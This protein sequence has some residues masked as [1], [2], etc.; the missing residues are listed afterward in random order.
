MTAAIYARYSDPKQNE[1]SIT[2]QNRVAEAWAKQE[3]VRVSHFYNDKAM[4]GAVR[5]RPDYLKM[6]DDAAA[7]LFEILIIHDLS[8]LSR[9]DYEL[10]GVLRKLIWLGVRVIGV[11][12]GY[13]STRSGHKIH[14]GFK[15]LMN[16]LHL[17]DIRSWTI[18]GMKGKAVDGFN[19]GGRT[20]GYRNVPIEDPTG[21]KDDYGRPAIIAV[22]YEIDEEQA[23]IV[24]KIYSWYAAGY[25]YTWIASELNKQGIKASRG[26][27]WAMTAI[28]VILDNEMY[29]GT[30]IWNRH[31]WVKH[32]DSGKRT[33]K[34]RP[35]EEW[36]IKDMPDLRIVPE[37]IMAAV[38]LRQKKNAT[39]YNSVMPQSSRRKYLFSGLMVCA[40]CGGNFV[41]AA[42]GRYGCI[43]NKNR[44]STVC[45]NSATVSRHIIEDRLL[46]GIKEQLLAPQAVEKFKRVAVQLL[47]RENRNDHK[48]AYMRQLK[49]AE[50][51]RDNIMTAIKAGI[52]TATTKTAL[53]S[54][55]NIIEEVK[56]RIK[57]S[58]RLNLSG[59]LPR[60]TERYQQAIQGLAGEFAGHTDQAREIIRSL[61][62]DNIMIH[63]RSG[64][65][66]AEIKS[67]MEVVFARLIGQ[68]FDWRGCG[69]GI[70]SE[71]NFIS[72]EPRLHDSTPLKYRETNK[73]KLIK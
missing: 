68:E 26:G 72:L 71:S 14:S 44:G 32:P 53:E 33:Y 67:N 1:V 12:D 62:G 34:K 15:G 39:A 5:A 49:E 36:V 46:S 40:E 69:G 29:T 11:A 66:E 31:Q 55:E 38:R 60:A 18:K 19:C 63:R 7:G 8:R 59:I 58:E 61:M 13:D 51:E 16:E 73:L 50:R 57:Q 43:M 23:N 10:K 52:V 35:R 47:E 22:K 2:D 45:T 56:A 42:A 25:S 54:C 27:S 20:Y 9:D 37:D 70:C 3:G 24:R 17:D 41:L 21:K 65:L 64:H 28:K 30:V 4:T 6:I 48:T